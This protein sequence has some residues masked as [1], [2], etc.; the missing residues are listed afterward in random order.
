MIEGPERAEPQL[1]NAT[2]TIGET[3]PARVLRRQLDAKMQFPT[4]CLHRN[5]LSF[6][7]IAAYSSLR[8]LLELSSWRCD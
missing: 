4:A 3:R 6:V 5:V 8:N 7:E 2:D 1:L